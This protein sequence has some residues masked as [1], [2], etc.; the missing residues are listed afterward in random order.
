MTDPVLA[1]IL[2]PLAV[3][4]DP[5]DVME[6]RMSAPE[7]I[8]IEKTDASK[9]EVVDATLTLGRIKRICTNL[10]NRYG[11]IFNGD[12][13]PKISCNLP[14]GHRFEC[15]VGSSAEDG[16]SLS[17]RC[18]Q[19]YQIEFARYGLEEELSA[20]I[21]DYVTSD[22]H[23]LVSGGTKTGKTT[24]LNLLLRQIPTSTRL[25][26]AQDTPEIDRAQFPDC[27]SLL[28]SRGGSAPSMLDWQGVYDH[29]NRISPDRVVFGEI[30]TENA[31]CALSILNSGASG[32]MCTL[33]AE[34][35]AQALDSKFDQVVAMAGYHIPP[36]KTYLG[37]LVDM[38]IQ[39]KRDD[40]VRYISDIFLP[41]ESRY[42]LRGE[43]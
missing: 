24:L 10:A 41:K 39:I 38:V 14:E 33:H 20:Q 5:L 3:H 42:L 7:R 2:A 9:I 21:I 37:A 6:V 22:K 43:R 29:I 36:V 12:D 23:I 34:S 11:V 18:K 30:S 13:A 27:V 19:P 28:S 16:V 15:L 4:Y 8:T 1:S 40:G 25:V 26:L 31:F 35:P 17:I 32:F